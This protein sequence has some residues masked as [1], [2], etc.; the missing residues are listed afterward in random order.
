MGRAGFWT[1]HTLTFFLSLLSE[2]SNS[3]W[4]SIYS[5]SGI[6]RNQKMRFKGHGKMCG[7]I[8]KYYAT[9]HTENLQVLVPLG[10]PGTNPHRSSESCTMVWRC[11]PVPPLHFQNL[12]S[13]CVKLVFTPPFSARSLFAFLETPF[14]TLTSQSLA[15]SWLH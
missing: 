6:L 11:D 3:L 2:Q 14:C 10:N 13:R 12:C 1:E 15:P 8:C 7:E 4:L 9:C 5:L